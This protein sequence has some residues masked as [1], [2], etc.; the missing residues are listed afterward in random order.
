MILFHGPTIVKYTTSADSLT[1]TEQ[2]CSRDTQSCQTTLTADIP[3]EASTAPSQATLTFD[4]PDEASTAPSQ[5]TLTSD[6]PD[7]ASTAPSQTTLT[8]DIP[9]E[10]STAPSQTTLTTDIPDEA[11]AAP[12]TTDGPATTTSPP[13]SAALC[14]GDYQLACGR[15]LSDGD[16]SGKT[17]A[18]AQQYCTDNGGHL[19][20]PKTLTDLLCVHD[21]L[22]KQGINQP[23]V[24]ADDVEKP[25]QIMWNDGTAL[26]KN[27]P[28]WDL[29]EPSPQPSGQSC[30]RYFSD[31]LG[32]SNSGWG[33]H[34]YICQKDC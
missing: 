10:A 2:S 7:K 24:G 4:I 27:S 16:K 13:C 32:V 25:G 1:E 18:D 23:W 5:T 29:N 22:L 14:S 9:D 6:I 12:S 8:S 30:V 31:K 28:L 21:F 11:S 34:N 3:D 15:C 19:A 26:P 33:T 17:Y 20:M